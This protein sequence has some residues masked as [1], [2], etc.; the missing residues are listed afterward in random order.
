MIIAEVVGAERVV[1][2]L[3]YAPN[4]IRQQMKDAIDFLGMSILRG[5]QARLKG[6]ALNV[7]TGNLRRS[8]NY[9]FTEGSMGTMTGSVGT[10][11]VYGRFWEKGFRG[12]VNVKAFT[13]KVQGRSTFNG[14]KKM[15][16]GI[17]FVRAHTRNVSQNPRPFLLPE[18]EAQRAEIK[19]RLLKAGAVM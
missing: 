7:R 2:N 10:N 15:S 8:I 13:R 14:K 1:A 16:Q 6:V 18:L 9:R 19:R 4:K 3:R 5:V 17:G 11:L 12:V